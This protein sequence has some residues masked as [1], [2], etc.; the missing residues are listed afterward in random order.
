MR[1]WALVCSTNLELRKQSGIHESVA[2][3]AKSNQSLSCS[4]TRRSLLEACMSPY[5]FVR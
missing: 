2:R 4:I 5:R 3:E 1:T